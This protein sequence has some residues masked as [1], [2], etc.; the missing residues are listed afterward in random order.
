MSSGSAGR[1]VRPALAR[2]LLKWLLPADDRA[3]VLADL[4]DRADRIA[5]ADSPASARRWYRA[6]VRRALPTLVAT[7]VMGAGTGFRTDAGQD[8]RMALRTVRTRPL[9]ALGFSGTLA[10]A[11][12]STTVLATVAWSLWLSPLP[13]PESDR[14]VR[15][16]EREDGRGLDEP[17]GLSWVSPPVFE[18]LDRT[19]W[20]SLTGVAAVTDQ[21][22]EIDREGE[23][24]VVDG[25]RVS[26]GFFATLGLAP[27]LG[28]VTW[29]EGAAEVVI[30]TAMWEREFGSDPEMARTGMLTIGGEPHRVVGVV[31]VDRGYPRAKD[32]VM[33]LRFGP[34]DLSEGMRGARYLSV[35][36]RLAS[37]ASPAQAESELSSFIASLGARHPQNAGWGSHVVGLQDDLTAPFREMLRLLLAAGVVFLVLAAVNVAGLVA[38]RGVERRPEFAVRRALGASEARIARAAVVEGLTLGLLGVVL[39]LP[40]ATIVLPRVA[41]ALP[42]G[43]PRRES[44][45]LDWPTALAFAGLGLG[46]AVLVGWVGQRLARGSGP[47]SRLGAHGPGRRSVAAGLRGRRALVVAQVTLTTLLLASGALVVNRTLD[48]S[49]IDLGFSA[50]GVTA[51]GLML[52]EGSYPSPD[53]R[54][55]AL[56]RVLGALESRGVVAG[57]I[58][59]PPMA[60]SNMNWGYFA[61]GT[62]EEA[63][64]QYHVA[65]VAALQVMG[66]EVEAGRGLRTDEPAPAILINRTLADAHFPAGDAVGRT[67][68]LLGTRRTVVG[69]VADTRHF[70]PDQPSPKELYVPLDDDPWGYSHIVVRGG[71]EAG[72]SIED[73]VRSVDPSLDPLEPF[74]YS[75]RV[76]AWFSTLRLQLTVVVALGLIGAL[77]AGLGLYTIIAYHVR[78]STREIGIRRA[79]GAPVALVMAA[80]F[81]QAAAMGVAGGVLG[82]AAWSALD[83]WVGTMLDVEEPAGWGVLGGVLLVV[84]AMSL[85]ASLLP[86]LRASRIDPR[87]ALRA[88]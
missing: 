30:S 45:A 20:T 19:E 76:V 31:D 12:A 86:A 16:Y 37:G 8:L 87:A 79:L 43:V 5:A 36:G 80:A 71:S 44:V 29:Q 42:S 83:R 65:S 38:A 41:G 51:A 15:I 85:V 26:G 1:A 74:P 57:V 6:Q 33:P 13:L 40:V 34:D 14:L 28:R 4:D 84:V 61:E 62:D 77:L 23:R 69:V 66:I 60:G 11:L 72:R 68:S 35:V 2:R 46:V 17:N 67:V 47:A 52:P 81:R 59:N 49:R 9:F 88:D 24:A 82:L 73:A 3:F 63:W 25:Y 78:A 56:Q 64:A 7:R 18:E 53:A 39:A 50:E 21:S 27:R 48:L 32:I 75:T 55:D 70:G 54:R 58:T 10:V 22:F